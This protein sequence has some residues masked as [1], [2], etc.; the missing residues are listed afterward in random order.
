MAPWSPIL[1]IHENT[2]N[3]L[4]PDVSVFNC[5]GNWYHD[6]MSRVAAGCSPLAPCCTSC[7]LHKW[8][9]KQL[10]AYPSTQ[11]LCTLKN[12][13]TT[14]KVRNC[15]IAD[16]SILVKSNLYGKIC[17]LRILPIKRRKNCYFP[18]ET[19]SFSRLLGYRQ[20]PFFLRY[21]SFL[22]MSSVMT[23]EPRDSSEPKLFH[24]LAPGTRICSPRIFSFVSCAF[25]YGVCCRINLGKYVSAYLLGSPQLRMRNFNCLSVW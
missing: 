23:S 15:K 24:S 9:R 11:I 13:R 5:R 12:T 17:R 7:T 3:N 14:R 25:D 20:P 6:D 4:V 19:G 1:N 16:N 2:R 22:Y 8:Q 21:A 10:E 18:R